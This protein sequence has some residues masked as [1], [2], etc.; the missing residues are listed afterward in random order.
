MSGPA[1]GFHELAAWQVMTLIRIAVARRSIC[2]TDVMYLSLAQR[3]QR[4]K[5]KRLA[6]TLNER[7]VNNFCRRFTDPCLYGQ[8]G[9]HRVVFAADVAE[10]NICPKRW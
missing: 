4:D 10:P 2:G 6:L 7:K 3:F 8:F 5:R 1:A 9:A